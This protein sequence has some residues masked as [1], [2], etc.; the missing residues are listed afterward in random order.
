[1]A[2]TTSE[3]SH[4]IMPMLAGDVGRED[5]YG[6]VVGEEPELEF[7]R[8][9]VRVELAVSAGRDRILR[10]AIRRIPAIPRASFNTCCC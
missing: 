4:D 9:G 7:A 5:E 8:V 1:M 6:D 2:I 3:I 10:D